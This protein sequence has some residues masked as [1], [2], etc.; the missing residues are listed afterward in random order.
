MITFSAHGE[1]GRVSEARND[2]CLDRLGINHRDKCRAVH[3]VREQRSEH[4][5][6][7]ARG[8][9]VHIV[10]PVNQNDGAFPRLRGSGDCFVG[11]D[12]LGEHPL[13]N[14]PG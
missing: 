12:R 4:M 5:S 10:R 3:V 14:A 9:S 8:S 1:N 2:G 11:S 6:A 7:V 13:P